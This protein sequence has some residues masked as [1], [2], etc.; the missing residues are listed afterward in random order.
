MPN[1][2]VVLARG[3]HGGLEPG[4]VAA[5]VAWETPMPPPLLPLANRPLVRHALDW[6]DEA[7][8]RQVALVAEAGLACEMRP[9]IG[10]GSRWS[11]ELAVL[12][13]APGEGLSETFEDLTGFL[14]GDPFVLHLAD[15]LSGAALRALI[16]EEPPY[17]H[18]SVALVRRTEWEDRA[19]VVELNARRNWRR[20]RPEAPELRG[21]TCAGVFVLGG[22]LAGAAS[23]AEVQSPNELESFAGRVA[24]LGGSVQTR[25]VADWWRLGPG[26]EAFLAGNRF[27]LRALAPEPDSPALLDS[28]I[29]G[30]VAIDRSARVESSI[31]R[32]PAVI[33]P[34]AVLREAYVGPYTSIGREVT[35]EGAEVENSVVLPRTSIRHLGGRLEASVVGPGA[36]IFRDFR[37]PKA[38]RLNVGEGAEVSLA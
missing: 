3:A 26:H 37:L 22:A 28:R 20:R 35:I 9:A 10:D 23:A 25:E 21:Q 19:E 33:G 18:E 14:G 32:G 12:E 38:L 16:G 34:G 1:K 24:E 2:A 17:G 7:G 15:S 27:A 29:E 30:S 36:R 4:G 8:I 6:L 11:F 13:Q 31:V 5:R